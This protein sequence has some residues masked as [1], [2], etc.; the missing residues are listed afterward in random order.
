MMD[1]PGIIVK[2]QD[3]LLR[4]T[5]RLVYLSELNFGSEHSLRNIY[6]Y[7]R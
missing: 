2:N 4:S 5:E 3:F 6:M 1:D 7:D